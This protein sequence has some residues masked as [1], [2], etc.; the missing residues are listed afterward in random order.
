MDDAIASVVAHMDP[1]TV[2]LVMSD[3]GMTPDGNHG[4][5]SDDEV[6]AALLAYSPRGLNRRPL[7]RSSK[8]SAIRLFSLALR[9]G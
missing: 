5:A 4:G 3:H 7:S 8:R 9:G 6:N 1:D 2:L